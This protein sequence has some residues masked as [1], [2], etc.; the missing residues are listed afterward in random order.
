MSLMA[1]NIFVVS[2]SVAGVKKLSKNPITWPSTAK[3]GLVTIITCRM[4]TTVSALFNTFIPVE[5]E[6]VARL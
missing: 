2:L 1:F 4:S 3:Y 6:A 5:D